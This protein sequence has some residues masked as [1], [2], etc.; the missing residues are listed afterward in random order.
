MEGF[1]E[2]MAVTRHLSSENRRT[3]NEIGQESQAFLI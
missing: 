3:K 2:K 1:L